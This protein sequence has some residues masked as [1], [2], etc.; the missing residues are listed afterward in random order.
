MRMML[1]SCLMATTLAMP[2]LAKGKTIPF[3]VSERPDCSSVFKA[4]DDAL[5]A[6]DAQVEALKKA[7]ESARKEADDCYKASKPSSSGGW[8][9]PLAIGIAGGILLGVAVGR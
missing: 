1:L 5:K 4:C 8:L 9:V 7:V 3:I 6:K 2:S